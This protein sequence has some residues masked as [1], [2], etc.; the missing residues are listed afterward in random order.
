MTKIPKKI[1]YCWFGENPLN[2]LSIK[3]INS[4]KKYLPDYEIVMW[5]ESNF[6][7]HENNYIKQAYQAKKYAFVSDYIRLH[8][9][10]NHGGIYMDTDVEVIKSLD[11]FLK[12]SAFSGFENKDNIPTGIMGSK[13]NN[14]WIKKL[15]DYYDNKNFI[16]EDG[17]YDLTT[18]VTTITKISKEIF[19]IKLNNMYQNND[20]FTIYPKDFFC[21]KSYETGNIIITS[22]TYAIHH[23]NGSWLD[24]KSKNNQKFNYKVI[25]YFGK[26]FGNKII[27][28]RRIFNNQSQS[29]KKVI[30]KLFLKLF[31]N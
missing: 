26:S 3:C 14:L 16:L 22:N 12:H 10:Y 11:V 29:L 9:L 18:N 24:E 2:E 8:I 17:S 4:W 23:F 7:I 20:I 5:N 30:K 13:K 6:N 21:P 31:R 27:K 19:D 15:L 1:H 28:F 25:K